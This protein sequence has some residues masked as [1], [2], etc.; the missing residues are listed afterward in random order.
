MTNIGNILNGV[1]VSTAVKSQNFE[2]FK[3][4]TMNRLVELCYGTEM[5]I[6]GYSL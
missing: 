2:R 4:N 5:V 6:H 3:D 1:L